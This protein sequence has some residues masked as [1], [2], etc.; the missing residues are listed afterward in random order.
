MGWQ[1]FEGSRHRV[2]GGSRFVDPRPPLEPKY[3]TSFAR[4]AEPV[5]EAAQSRRFEA[6]SGIRHDSGTGA[7]TVE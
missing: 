1:K 5:G 4:G 7:R 6:S 2:P 3:R